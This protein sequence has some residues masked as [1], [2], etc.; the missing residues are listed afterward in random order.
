MKKICNDKKGSDKKLHAFISFAIGI[1]TGGLLSLINFGSA[2]FSALI[3]F[4]LV[5]AIGIAKELHDR[6]QSGNHF[7]VWDLL[8]DAIGAFGG[9][10]IAFIASY[11]TWHV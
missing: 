5:M 10:V 6:R 7:C 11:F 4:A 2:F 8:A 9:S 3:T 1:M